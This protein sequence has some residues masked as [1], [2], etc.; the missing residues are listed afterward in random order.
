MTVSSWATSHGFDPAVVRAL[1]SGRTPGDGDKHTRS[2]SRRVSGPDR[3][4][5][6]RLRRDGS[7]KPRDRSAR[8]K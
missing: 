7:C 5:R 6:L 3:I 8:R 1:L 4:A 2:Q